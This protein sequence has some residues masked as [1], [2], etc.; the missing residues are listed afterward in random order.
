MLGERR[1]DDPYARAALLRSLLERI[2][3]N[4]A[5]R[6]QDEE[7]SGTIKELAIVRP[8]KHRAIAAGQDPSHA[9]R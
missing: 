8:R 6:G 3:A 4:T 9:R 1:N 2:R 5:C 7:K